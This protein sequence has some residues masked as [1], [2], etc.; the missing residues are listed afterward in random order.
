MDGEGPPV[1]TDVSTVTDEPQPMSPTTAAAGPALLPDAALPAVTLLPVVPKDLGRYEAADRHVK[2]Y[3]Y[4]VGPLLFC[5]PLYPI[6]RDRRGQWER[7]IH[8]EGNPYF[9][10]GDQ[11]V[12]TLC[13]II[14]DGVN[15]C[16]KA[17]VAEVGRRMRVHRP[18]DSITRDLPS[19]RPDVEVQINQWHYGIPEWELCINVVDA[20]KGECRYYIA[21]WSK[22]CVF[23]LEDDADSDS[24]PGVLDLDKLKL[25]PKSSWDHLRTMFEGHFWKHAEFFSCHRNLPPGSLDELKAWCLW[26]TIDRL[27]CYDSTVSST[28]EDL[29]I[30]MQLFD[31]KWDHPLAR[32]SLHAAV[33]RLWNTRISVDR[34]HN[35]HGEHSA[36]L[37]RH[38]SRFSQAY[39]H[40]T[41]HWTLHLISKKFLF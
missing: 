16:V 28:V 31:H 25:K 40:Y 2:A 41:L 24:N 4:T 26:A 11:Q 17:V 36:R 7:H 34:Q 22:R 19:S 37:S 27:T 29:Q 39:H 6:N 1:F 3:N 8:P 10:H 18:Q 38:Q 23:W 12:V 21:D 9:Y 14:D 35:L 20:K 33:A 30:F 13:D 5:D 15:D 32:G